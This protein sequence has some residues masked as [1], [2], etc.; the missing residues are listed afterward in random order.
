MLPNTSAK[1]PELYLFIINIFSLI[2]FFFPLDHLTQQ[3]FFS[4]LLS[5][6]EPEPQQSPWAPGIPQLLEELSSRFRPDLNPRHHTEN[7]TNQNDFLIFSWKTI[8]WT[9]FWTALLKACQLVRFFPDEA[10]KRCSSTAPFKQLHNR[11]SWRWQKLGRQK[12]MEMVTNIILNEAATK[13]SSVTLQFRGKAESWEYSEF[14]FQREQTI[15]RRTAVN[16]MCLLAKFPKHLAPPLNLPAWAWLT[17]SSSKLL[18]HQSTGETPKWHF[19]DWIW[20]KLK[21]CE[22]SV[23]QWLHSPGRLIASL[24]QAHAYSGAARRWSARA[25]IN[26]IL[27]SMADLL[28]CSD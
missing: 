6:T 3:P 8:P 1:Y 15:V 19:L 5:T 18:P 27:R 12:S 11:L 10:S 21:T 28:P 16:L 17:S 9:Y 26:G 25:H 7:I 22:S 14:F 13:H 23:Q 4:V 24:S 2:I 20:K